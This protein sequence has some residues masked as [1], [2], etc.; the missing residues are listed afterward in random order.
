MNTHTMKGLL[1]ISFITLAACTYDKNIS[2]E[3]IESFPIKVGNSWEYSS[4][5]IVKIYES[6]LSNIAIEVDTISRNYI[7]RVENDIILNDTMRVFQFSSTRVGGKYKSIEYCY[8]D[9]AGLHTY[10][11]SSG[12]SH[13]F[14]KKGFIE[15][16]IEKVNE[17]FG[18]FSPVYLLE[19]DFTVFPISRHNLKFPLELHSKWTYTFPYSP[20]FLQIDKEIVGYENIKIANRNFSCYKIKWIYLENKFFDGMT[21][22]DWVS[23]E[24]LIK[25]EI[26]GGRSRLTTPDGE[27]IGSSQLTEIIA[28]TSLSLSL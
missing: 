21:I 17:S 2:Y 27:S 12:G 18:V 1:L 4:M 20:F 24:G 11:N 25:R 22:F 26:V 10:A 7:V 14:P 19:A 15:T 8:W 9:S 13:V 5:S 16:N 6:E 3:S 23:S 28:L